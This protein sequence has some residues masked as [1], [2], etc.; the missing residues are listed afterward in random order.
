V[1]DGRKISPAEWDFTKLPHDESGACWF[2]EC[3]RELVLTF[4]GKA[5]RR[6]QAEVEELRVATR[7]RSDKKRRERLAIEPLRKVIAA[8]FKQWPKEPYQT[9][10]AGQRRALLR[11]SAPEF[12]DP[13][14]YVMRELLPYLT[15]ER[16]RWLLFQLLTE[17]HFPGVKTQGV[18][19]SDY[20]LDWRS[21]Q[22]F[23]ALESNNS[24][25][26]VAI[27]IDPADGPA[28][29]IK[30]CRA[31]YNQLVP[32]N[33][34]GKGRKPG[35]ANLLARSRADLKRLGVYRLLTVFGLTQQEA[36]ALIIDRL[37][38]AYYG[39]N[40]SREANKCRAY[41]RRCVETL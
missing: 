34:R 38:K 2:Y 5:T 1:S 11:R 8:I 6:L 41:L 12:A 37:G 9:I 40:L 3:T 31:L 15:T 39:S 32:V 29:F 26:L 4:P 22:P 16:A 28:Q 7:L 10:E 19:R 24:R 23:A 13:E 35:Y 30:Q 17:S 21:G 18:A 36:I 33:E 20:D 27:L 14:N 25:Y